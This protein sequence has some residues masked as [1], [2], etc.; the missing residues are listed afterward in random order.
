MRNG[1][2]PEHILNLATRW[3]GRLISA[4]GSFALMERSLIPIE[5][6][7]WWG[8]EPVWAY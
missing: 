2:I 8:S 6:E 5:K 1:G 7:K 4:P 3:S